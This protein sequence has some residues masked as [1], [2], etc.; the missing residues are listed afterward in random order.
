MH[1]KG[2]K[3]ENIH[4]EGLESYCSLLQGVSIEDDEDWVM[5]VEKDISAC[6]NG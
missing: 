2:N 1:Q 5:E 3:V 6:G 4:T